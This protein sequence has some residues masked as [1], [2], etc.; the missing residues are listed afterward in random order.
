MSDRETT[1]YTPESS[2]ANPRQM[3]AEMFRDL[4]R[5]R[6]LAWRLAVRDILAQYRQAF[7]GLLWAFITPVATTITWIFLAGAGVVSV[8]ETDL[9]YP[10]YVFTGTLL[11][12][13]LLDAMNSPLQRTNQSRDMLAKLNFPREA[14][15][16][17]GLYQLLFNSGIKIV[18]LLIALLV[19]GINPG[20]S[21]LLFPLGVVSLLLV[22]TAIGLMLTPIG[23]LYTDVG[24]AVPLLM[25]FL[26]Y[27][28]PV[29]FPLPR[30]GWVATIYQINP[31]T[32]L[33][34]TSRDWLT[35]FSPEFLGYF[36]VVN[37][38]AFGLL[39]VAWIA[40]RLAMPIIIERMSA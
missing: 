28:T 23:M 14:L 30:E 4:R 24:R 27:L 6:E 26:M 21:L 29:V 3:V 19:V 1:V 35:G 39:L 5:G 2:L 25:G 40:Y 37:L 13:I 32:P 38:L 7:L 12:S 33:I 34:L 16:V 20:W 18:L 8:G 22:G 11:W 15:V 17:S 9:P 10:V 36:L 31:F